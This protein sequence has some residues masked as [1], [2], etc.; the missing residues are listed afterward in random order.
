MHPLSESAVFTAFLT[1][2]CRSGIS[3]HAVLLNPPSGLLHLAA[4]YFSE[5][6]F[7]HML[8]D[9]NKTCFSCM[10]NGWTYFC[11]LQI[12]NCAICYVD[13]EEESKKENEDENDDRIFPETF[14]LVSQAKPHPFINASRL[15]LP[16]CPGTLRTVIN[17][18]LYP[19][20]SIWRLELFIAA[21]FKYSE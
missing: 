5:P 17:I 21:L 4:G 1:S 13:T 20:V 8:S 6:Q 9:G 3:R 15:E 19:Y 7:P 10:R 11:A 14:P 12:L 18:Y 16:Q 2:Q